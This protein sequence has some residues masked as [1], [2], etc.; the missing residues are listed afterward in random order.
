MV[1]W[2]ASLSEDPKGIL[3]KSESQAAS[4]PF[5]ESWF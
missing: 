3:A 2:I 4:D 5:Y 1:F